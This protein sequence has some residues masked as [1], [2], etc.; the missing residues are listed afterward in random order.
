MIC[1]ITKKECIGDQC[2]WHFQE[3]AEDGVTPVANMRGCSI[4]MIAQ[5][6]MEIRPQTLDVKDILKDAPWH[7]GVIQEGGWRP[8][9]DMDVNH[10]ERW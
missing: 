8:L 5:Y 7:H 3:V 10:N 1:P 4:N 6:L 9:A 2:A